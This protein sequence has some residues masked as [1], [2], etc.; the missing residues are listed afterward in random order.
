MA[1]TPS[2]RQGL[3]KLV[4]FEAQSRTARAWR[5]IATF[6]DRGAA[7]AEAERTLR[8]HRTPAVRVIQVLYNDATSECREYTVFRATSFDDD[9]RDAQNG[10]GK[11][12]TGRA[13]D[14]GHEAKGG[15]ASQ[16]WSH[17]LPDW[18]TTGLTLS[19][20]FLCFF[21]LIFWMR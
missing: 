8:A 6:D 15:A 7:I 14:D 13:A 5:T 3:G 12:E 18:P 9:G 11:A 1:R 20:A 17:W 16:R 21:V 10:A 19:L 4:T 2:N